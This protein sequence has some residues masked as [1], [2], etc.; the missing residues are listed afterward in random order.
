MNRKILTVIPLLFLC[1]GV[2][3]GEIGSGN[4]GNIATSTSDDEGGAESSSW[5]D[6]LDSLFESL[7]DEES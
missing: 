7:A 1:Q 4:T 3:A 2:F 5:R 6:C